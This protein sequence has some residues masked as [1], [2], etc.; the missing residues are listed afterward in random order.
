MCFGGSHT[1]SGVTRPM[2]HALGDDGHEGVLDGH[3]PHPGHI[4]PH[5]TDQH[6]AMATHPTPT[7]FTRPGGV[8]WG[9]GVDTHK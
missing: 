4:L 9:G 7:A 2:G 8:G 6:A 1:V 5:P 3:F